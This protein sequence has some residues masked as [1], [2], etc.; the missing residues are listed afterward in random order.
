[1][2]Q[3][4][5]QCIGLRIPVDFDWVSRPIPRSTSAELWFATP[6]DPYDASASGVDFIRG[7]GHAYPRTLQGGV[8]LM[9]NMKIKP[10][11]ESR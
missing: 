2:V 4:D 9:R 7:N 11:G 3:L 5:E 6:H 8:R 10:D 1:M